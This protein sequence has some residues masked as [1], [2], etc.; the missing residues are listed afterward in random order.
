MRPIGPLVIP[1]P[2]FSPDGASVAYGGLTGA[3]AIW[4][5]ESGALVKTLTPPPATTEHEFVDPAVA[6]LYVGQLAYSPDGTKLVSAALET[7][8]LFDV[9]SGRQVAQLGGW[10]TLATNATFTPDGDMIV[11]SGFLSAT[12]VFDAATG[13]PIGAPIGDGTNAFL[14]TN[15]PPGTLTISDFAGVIKVVDLATRTLVGPPMTGVAVPVSSVDVLP[16]AR[17]LIAGF[18]ASPNGVAQLFDITTGHPIGAPFP[19]LGPYSAANVRPDGKVMI[20][21]DGAGMVRWNID[22]D[23]WR[24]TACTIAGRNLTPEEWTQFLPNGDPYRATCPDYPLR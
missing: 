14:A 12:M 16:G 2:T 13:D 18:Y 17:Q 15:G 23:T 4:D 9:G 21:G 11:I 3:V 8:T 20:T 5:V 6:P 22:S 24:Q 19:S 7:A 10:D 1:E